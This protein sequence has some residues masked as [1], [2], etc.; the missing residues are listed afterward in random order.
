M[1]AERVRAMYLLAMAMAEVQAPTYQGSCGVKIIATIKPVRTAPLGNSHSP[2]ILRRISRSIAAATATAAARPGTIRRIPSC[3]AV[4][5]IRITRTIMRRPL[6]VWKNRHIAELEVLMH[7]LSGM[8]DERGRIR[9]DAIR[10]RARRR[11]PRGRPGAGS[12]KDQSIHAQAIEELNP[13]CRT[14]N[15]SRR[16]QRIRQHCG[17]SDDGHAGHAIG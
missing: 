10:T 16:C 8:A 13:F 5:A 11:G 3:G 12:R 14:Q 15:E 6:G 7:P 17:R 1:L 4:T 9:R 2:C